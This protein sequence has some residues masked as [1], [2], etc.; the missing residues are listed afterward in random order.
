M[1]SSMNEPNPYA[2]PVADLEAPAGEAADPGG[3]PAFKLYTPGHVMLATFLGTPAAGL[4]L[5]WANRRRLGDAGGA[6]EA[7]IVGAVGT[8]MLFAAGFALP[9][10]A[11]RVL[12]IAALFAAGQ[13]ARRDAGRL[14]AHARRGG[15]K[16]SGWK[17]AG[18]GA[19]GFLAVV[20]VLGGVFFL[21]G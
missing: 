19:L 7:L 15:Q 13:Y 17:A 9:E 5:V 11:G 1:P 10:A 20:A 4:Y 6:T 2:P 12:P 8:A 21:L 18:V 14:D 3:R 16:E